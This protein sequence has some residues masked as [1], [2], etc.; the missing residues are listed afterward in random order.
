MNRIK[1]FV[2]LILIS[3]LILYFGGWGLIWGEPGTSILEA[4]R[5]AIGVSGNMYGVAYVHRFFNSLIIAWILFAFALFFVV[6]AFITLIF[7]SKN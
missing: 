7:G 1:V 2:L 6:R 5:A 4:N 3:V